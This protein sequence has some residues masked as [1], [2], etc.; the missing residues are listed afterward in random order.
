[1]PSGE[2]RRRA[3]SGRTACTDRGGGG[4]RPAPLA[5]RLIGQTAS[6]RPYSTTRYVRGRTPRSRHLTFLARWPSRQAMQ[7]ARDRI[8]E[9]TDRQRLLVPVE[10]IVQDVNRFPRG[11]AG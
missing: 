3:V 4:R 8:H 7:H 10:E 6:R 9:L 1:M 2:R 5:A 11:W